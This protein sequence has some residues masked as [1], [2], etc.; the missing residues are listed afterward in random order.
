[1]T[2][3]QILEAYMVFGGVPYYWS[4][5]QRGSSITSEIDRLFFSPDGELHD[6]FE[7][8]YASLFKKSEPYIR[9]VELLAKKKTGMTR[10]E[11]LA[12][13]KFEDNGSFSDLLKD[14]EWCGF[15]RSYSQIGYRAKYEIYQLIDHFTLF[16]YEYMAGVRA[17]LS[18]NA[19]ATMPIDIVNF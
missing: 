13:G 9:I 4:L 16:Y 2:R 11:L 1:M 12:A 17:P 14:L 5:L 8:L 18:L 3:K 10:Q 15:I 7:M 6:E 19:Y